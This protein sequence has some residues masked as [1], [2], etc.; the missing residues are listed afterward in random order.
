ML[1]PGEA[2]GHATELEPKFL[3]FDSQDHGLPA[4]I[5]ANIGRR[6]KSPWTVTHCLCRAGP[7]KDTEEVTNQSEVLSCAA[8]LPG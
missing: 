8:V 4:P 7:R 2:A 6:L 5:F 1:Q 3:Q